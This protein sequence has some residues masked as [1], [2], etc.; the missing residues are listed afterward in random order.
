MLMK[1]FRVVLYI[2]KTFK[3]STY[4][5]NNCTVYIIM[6]NPSSRSSPK[7]NVA[8]ISC[9]NV[10][11]STFRTFTSHNVSQIRNCIVFVSLRFPLFFTLVILCSGILIGYFVHDVRIFHYRYQLFH[12]FQSTLSSTN[13]GIAPISYPGSQIISSPH[14]SSETNF[15]KIVTTKYDVQF[16]PVTLPPVLN[17]LQTVVLSLAKRDPLQNHEIILSLT[18][19]GPVETQ[20]QL[21]IDRLTVLGIK[22]KLV[23]IALDDKVIENICI[24]NNV[25][26]VRKDPVEYKYGKDRPYH[27]II[28]AMKFTYLEEI[29]AVGVNV[30]LSDTDVYYLDNPFCWF[31][32]DS[33]IEVQSDGISNPEA[34]GYHQPIDD[35]TILGDP[36]SFTIYFGNSGFFYIR[37]SEKTVAMMHAIAKRLEIIDIWDQAAFNDELWIP[38]YEDNHPFLGDNYE[39]ELYLLQQYWEVKPPGVLPG[40][41]SEQDD[42]DAED[43]GKSEEDENHRKN[44]RQLRLQLNAMKDEGQDKGIRNAVSLTDTNSVDY[45]IGKSSTTRSPKLTPDVELHVDTNRGNK[46]EEKNKATYVHRLLSILPTRTEDIMTNK[47]LLQQA[48]LW[49]REYKRRTAIGGRQPKIRIMDYTRF[50]N[51]KFTIHHHEKYSNQSY[52]VCPV[53]IHVNYHKQKMEGLNKVS[54]LFGPCLIS[55]KRTTCNFLSTDEPEGEPTLHKSLGTGTISWLMNR[56]GDGGHKNSIKHYQQSIIEKLRTDTNTNVLEEL[57]YYYRYCFATNLE[58]TDNGKED[59]RCRTIEKTGSKLGTSKVKEL[60]NKNMVDIMYKLRR[61]ELKQAFEEEYTRKR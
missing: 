32:R 2:F 22:E 18:N 53:T 52:A 46:E 61:E 17:E 12:E 36:W 29:L 45:G 49:L 26:C 9:F 31:H 28:S 6:S 25:V 42:Y 59:Q 33:D 5:T 43:G 55:E 37:S 21:F 14:K 24:P 39:H 54:E 30:L 10:Y 8:N 48:L 44:Q 60:R 41:E 7:T 19:S 40:K 13:G 35:G 15:Q 23:L 58:A 50:T 47:E 56:Y 1:G 38:R 11:R 3:G 57:E 51:S 34:Y 27:Q 4:D 16:V 20:V